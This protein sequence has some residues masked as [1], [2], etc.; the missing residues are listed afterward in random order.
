[1]NTDT[2]ADMLTRIRNALLRREGQVD[3]LASNICRGIL[4]VLKTEGFIRGFDEIQDGRQGIMR[5]FLKYGPDGEQLV[6]HMKRESKSSR[7]VYKQV[8]EIKPILGGLGVAVYTTPQG[9]V[10][11]RQARRLKVGGEL[12]CTIW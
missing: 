3:V 4:N 6:S 11:D 10:S 12:I 7:R 5:V 1:M 2:V 9:I 8:D